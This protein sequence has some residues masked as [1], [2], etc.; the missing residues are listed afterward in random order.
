MESKTQLE[1]ILKLYKDQRLEAIKINDDVYLEQLT[2]KINEVQDKLDSLNK[3]TSTKK[4]GKGGKWF[5]II[6]ISILLLILTGD[7][8][9][10]YF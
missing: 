4:S 10:S 2:I 5:A 7:E 9:L 3:T 6:G 8:I 1:S